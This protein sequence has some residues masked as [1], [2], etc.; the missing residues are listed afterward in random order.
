MRCPQSIWVAVEPRFGKSALAKR[1]DSG[2]GAGAELIEWSELD[3]IGGASLGT[4]RLQATFQTI[5]TKGAL[6]RRAASLLVRAD[7][8]IGAGGHAILTPVADVLLD[9]D[10]SKLCSRDGG[11][12]RLEATRVLAML[13]NVTQKEPAWIAS[14]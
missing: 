10:G 14:P 13:A 7:D 3:G 2:V 12:T 11:R 4:G 1:F 9:D 6:V 8:S 5:V